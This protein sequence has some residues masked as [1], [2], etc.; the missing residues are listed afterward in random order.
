V[1]AVCSELARL[2]EA[3]G[4]HAVRQVVFNTA[5]AC[6]ARSA[7]R[8][9]HVG[10][11][12]WPGANPVVAARFPSGQRDPAVKGALGAEGRSVVRGDW[13]RPGRRS[14]SSGRGRRREERPWRGGSARAHRR[15]GSRSRRVSHDD[16]VSSSACTRGERYLQTRSAAWPNHVAPEPVTPATAWW[17][18]PRTTRHLPATRSGITGAEADRRRPAQQIGVAATRGCSLKTVDCT[19]AAGD[20]ASVCKHR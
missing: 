12:R 2:T 11:D 17:R 18:L 16:G 1:T 19:R 20:I 10:S 7:A 13:R 3:D 14:R 4:R 8:E 5:E 15:W 6:L 9:T